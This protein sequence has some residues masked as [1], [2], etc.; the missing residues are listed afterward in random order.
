M[1]NLSENKASSEPFR[2]R[3]SVFLILWKS[4]PSAT[5]LNS[6]PV[7]SSVN[8]YHSQTLCG[9][10]YETMFILVYALV[11]M[12]HICV[13]IIYQDNKHTYIYIYILIKFI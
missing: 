7:L 1:K 11:F 8:G 3:N 9:C 5:V 10:M 2:C 4:V 13:C 6:N 12:Y